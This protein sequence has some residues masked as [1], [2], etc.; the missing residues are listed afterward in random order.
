M[1]KV[2][3]IGASSSK[4]S[5]NKALAEYA[6]SKLNNVEVINVDISKYN[7]LPVFSVDLESDNGAPSKIVELNNLIKSVDGFIISFA[8]HN[9]SYAA[10]YK[11]VYD[12]VSRQGGKV[13]NGKP[14]LLL[15]TSPGGR[16]GAAVLG[17]A[18]MLYPHQGAIVTGSFSLPSY[19]DNVSDNEITNPELSEKL[20]AEIEN[21]QNQ[22]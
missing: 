7:D 11:N 19:Y 15:S 18:V 10:G 22:L 12:W 9:G 16:G 20:T 17:N 8:E 14:A 2:I 6:G 3:T 1:K 4:N 5:I 13:F 21:F